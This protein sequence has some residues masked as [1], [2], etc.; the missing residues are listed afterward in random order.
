MNKLVKLK[1]LVSLSAKAV[2]KAVIKPVKIDFPLPNSVQGIENRLNSSNSYALPA[3]V[4]AK[5]KPTFLVGSNVRLQHLLSQHQD[6]LD[7]MVTVVGWARQTRLQAKDTI[8]FV[9]LVD[10]SNS[11]ALQVV[12][13]NTVPN[14]E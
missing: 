12:I 9:N 1:Y 6:Y 14:W 2:K 8:L 5:V 4:Y 11:V 13:D 7:K 3:S 10:G